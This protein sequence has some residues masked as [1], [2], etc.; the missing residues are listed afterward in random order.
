MAIAPITAP[1]DNEPVSPINILAGCVLYI[2]NPIKLPTS[3]KL[4][5][6]ISSNPTINDIKLKAINAI[7][8]NPPAKPSNPSVKFTA[9]DAPTNTNKINYPYNQ[10]NSI[11]IPS[12]PTT[13]EV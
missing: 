1:N 12:V 2:R 7:A 10:P 13:N 5:I 6:P 8:D 3:I 4:N 11:S 9:F